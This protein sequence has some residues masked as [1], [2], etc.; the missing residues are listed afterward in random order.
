[1]T[2]LLKRKEIESILPMKNV[3]DFV[4]QAFVQQALN[5]AVMPVRTC[6]PVEKNRGIVCSMPAYIE[7]MDA[8]GMK[9]VSTYRDNPG[10]FGLPSVQ[11]TI[12]MNNSETGQ[13][14]AIMD[15][16]YITGMRT[17]AASAI[18]TKHLARKDSETVG[19][20]GCGGQA[21]YQLQGQ[22]EVARI[23]KVK[24]YDVSKEYRDAFVKKASEILKNVKIEPVDDPEQVVKG[25][26]IIVTVTTSKK[27]IFDGNWVE[28]GTH[29]NGIGSYE[30]FARELD[31]TT[32]KRAKVVVDAYDA[33]FSE[34]GDIL[35]PIKEGA[36]TKGHVHAQ[37]GELVANLKPGRTNEKEITVFKT[38]GLAI[39]DVSTAIQVYKIALEKGI[40]TEFNFTSTT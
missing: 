33:A 3:I 29:I 8:L 26:D 13:V 40:G 9:I 14:M 39:E 5:R 27:P 16:V 37:L 15:G 20:F 30:P 35:I 18:A 25:S 22:C 32:I 6:I 11:A 2:K 10:K 21:I 31:T 28:D 7:A 24:A 1:M 23:K 4:E 34:A 19:L 36:I 12:L 17:A 38:T